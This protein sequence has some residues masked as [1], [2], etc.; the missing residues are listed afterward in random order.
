MTAP[1]SK[2]AARI[3]SLDGLRGLSIWLVMLA[4]ASGHFAGTSSTVRALHGFFAP[5][6]YFGVTAFFVISGF[7]ITSLLLKELDSTGRLDLARFYRRRAVRIL[8]AAL[9]YIAAILLFCKVTAA[10]ALYA[11]TFTTSYFYD[12]AAI[13]LQQ[14]WSLSVEEQFYLLWPLALSFGARRAKRY[15]WLI[16]FISPLLRTVLKYHGYTQS[17]HLAP[18]IADSI[19]CGCLLAFW[20]R[21]LREW[22]R[23]HLRSTPVF[24]TLCCFTAAVAAVLYRR[25]LV[26]LWGLVPILQAGIIAAAIERQ[27]KVLNAGPLVGSGLLSYSLYLWQ[28]TVFGVRRT[29]ELLR[30][31]PR[32]YLRVR[33]RIVS[34][35]R[36]A[37]IA[38]VEQRP[39]NHAQNQRA[40]LKGC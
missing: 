20:E 16:I 26:L 12:H 35:D 11:V 19:A 37:C 15:C 36:T 40:R 23:R 14:L 38:A 24:L 2:P 27:D 9:F 13:A 21:P 3:P 32:P 10:Q 31:T 25:D 8:P 18:A 34:A 6:A 5:A 33:L 1:P 29:S 17:A 4:H 39:Q 30:G 22:A 7:L 28:Q